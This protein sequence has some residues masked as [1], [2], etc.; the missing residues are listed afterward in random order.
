MQSEFIYE[1]DEQNFRPTL[2]TSQHTPVLVYLWAPSIAESTTLNEPLQQLA[3]TYQGSF[4]LARL[5]CEQQQGIAA[6]FGVQSLPTLVLLSQG[7]AVDGLVGP[8]SIEA[9]SQMLAKHLPSQDELAL[10]QV[11][12]LIA[13]AHYQDALNLIQTLEV[14]TQEHP[15]VLLL[16][17]QCLVET[18]QFDLA[19]ALLD[20]VPMQ[21]K[22]GTYQGLVAKIELNEQAANSPEIQQ[23]E[24]KLEQNPDDLSITCELALQ[25]H[26][27]NRDDEALNLL[28]SVLKKDLNALDGKIKS[29]FMSILSALGQN[30]AIAK[31]YR[32]YLYALLY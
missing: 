1:L 5:N 11:Q 10:K 24:E 13:N 14:T 31:Q 9:V 26:Q 2:E 28:L 21:Y 17:A 20:K 15:E 23:L 6:Q 8:Q 25:Y 18:K 12:D 7:Q 32:R 4:Q 30:H 3:Q 16:Q 19:K 27:V 29:E 22:D